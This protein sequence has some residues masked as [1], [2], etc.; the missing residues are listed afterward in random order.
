MRSIGL[1]S[2][3]TTKTRSSRKSV[4][5]QRE[6]QHPSPAGEGRVRGKSTQEKADFYPPHPNLLPEG[7]GAYA[8]TAT[9]CLML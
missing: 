7:E 2:I 4:T 6:A 5:I 3:V 1:K 9:V 8:P